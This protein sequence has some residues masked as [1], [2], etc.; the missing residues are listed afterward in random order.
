MKKNTLSMHSTVA[1]SANLS[2][3]IH[4]AKEAGF[5]C[6]EPTKKQLNQFLDAGYT[7]QDI[8]RLLG[9]L[10]ISAVGWLPDIERCG[11]DFTTLMREADALFSLVASVDSP[12]VELIN[13]PV[14][15]HAVDCFRKGL[16]YSGYMGTQ[17]LPLTEQQDVLVQNLRVLADLAAEYKLTLYFEPLCWTPFPSL[18]EGLPLIQRADR[19]NLKIVV[20]FYHNYI[21]GLDAEF[22]AKIPKEHILGVHACNAHEPD[23]NVPCEEIYRDI[24]FHEGK[25]PLLD[26]VKAIQATGFDGWWAYETFSKKEA[27]LNLLHFAKYVRA[28]LQKLIEP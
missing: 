14:D 19:E 25:V 2:T 5:D 23:D 9:Q 28:E 13:G 21:A 27:E 26:W 10:N 8:K 18:K 17:A 16:P 24:G 4:A 15:W 20:D 3:Y 22:L 11:D 7:P 12:A 1:G 6:I